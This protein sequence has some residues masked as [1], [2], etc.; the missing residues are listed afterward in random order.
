[1]QYVATV[2][3]RGSI[4]C[5]PIMS[6]LIPPPLALTRN[7]Y[8]TYNRFASGGNHAIVFVYGGDDSLDICI[9]ESVPLDLAADGQDEIT[10]RL[11]FVNGNR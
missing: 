6:W 3:A 2:F 7:A 4:F 5:V 1:M 11:L 8:Y 9:G 10:R